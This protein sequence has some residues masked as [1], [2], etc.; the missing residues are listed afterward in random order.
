M[1]LGAYDYLVKPIDAQE[2]KI[3]QKNAIET[4]GLKDKIRRIQKPNVE[5]YRFDLVGQNPQI[6]AMITTAQKVA[7]SPDTPLLITGETGTG[8]GILARAIHFSFA[9]LPG[10]LC[11]STVQPSPMT[12]SRASLLDTIAAPSP[13]QRAKAG[14]GVLKRPRAAIFSFMKSVPCRFQPS[15]NSWEFLMIGSSTEWEGADPIA[16]QPESSRSPVLTCR[17]LWKRANSEGISFSG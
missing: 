15:P 17:G 1:K 14:S 12:F 10:P 4:Q 7:R 3:T 9:E 6:K 2:L 16:C 11:R 13:A 5:R 8:K